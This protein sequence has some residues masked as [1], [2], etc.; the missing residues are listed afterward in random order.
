VYEKRQT[1]NTRDEGP[2]PSHDPGD[3]PAKCRQN[4][5]P[6]VLISLIQHRVAELV[7]YATGVG[8]V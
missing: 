3:D 7:I 4:Q 1:T 6:H 5:F 8:T 2:D